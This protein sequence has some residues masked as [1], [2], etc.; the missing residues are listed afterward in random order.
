V[1]AIDGTKVHANASRD[2]T[3]DYEQLARAIVEEAIETDAADTAAFGD[4]R[5]DEL[6]EIVASR[7]G[8][9][10]WLRAARQRLEQQR[11]EQPHPVPRSRQRDRT[12]RRSPTRR[13]PCRR[14]RS[15]SPIRTQRSCTGCAA[16]SRATTPKPSA[17]SSTSSSPR[18]S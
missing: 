10:G 9:E 14:A 13:R 5:G 8:R 4:R 17:T 18:K 15:T 7:Q 1:I 3:L 16:G 2:S 6:P 11:A 12:P